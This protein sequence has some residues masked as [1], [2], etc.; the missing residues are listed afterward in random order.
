MKRL[1]PLLL[2]LAACGGSETP[3]AAVPTE[4]SAPK[5]SAPSPD[6]ARQLISTSAD[7][8]DL[9]FTNAA[10]TLPTARAMMNAPAKNAAKALQRDGW[11]SMSGNGLVLT[12]K[13][14]NDRRFLL[15][16]NGS[17]DVVPL[18]KKEMG[19]VSAVRMN[20]DGTADADFTWR[21]QPN[22]L[23]TLL[24][25]DRFSGDQRATA[26]LLWDGSRW[27]MLKIAKKV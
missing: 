20:A 5:P 23:G 15:R 3:R 26:T 22:E 2:L 14:E 12:S 27:T 21:W 1:L 18:A 9:E 7:F 13:A 6:D 8:G 25:P 11:I 16:P 17:L 19:A 10:Y 24:A 4:T